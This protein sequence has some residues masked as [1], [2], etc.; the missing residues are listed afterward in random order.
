MR[1]YAE[2]EKGHQDRILPITPDFVEFLQ[3]TPLA[4]RHGTL[5][6]IVAGPTGVPMTA[7]RVGRVISDIG[8]RAKIV[9]NKAEGKFASAHDLRRSFGTRWA[10]RVQTGNV[11]TADEAP[12]D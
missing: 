5:F 11:T 12:I 10:K 8:K 3:K 1:I 6:P 7:A 9:V 4:D 2:A